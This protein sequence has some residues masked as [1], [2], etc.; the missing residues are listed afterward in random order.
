MKACHRPDEGAQPKPPLRLV[1][2]ENAADQRLDNFLFR[3]FARVP[4]SRIY[5]AIRT[6]EVRV[7]GKRVKPEYRI[8]AE[9]E[10]KMP[11]LTQPAVPATSARLSA[12]QRA[13]VRRA[14]L[15]ETREFIAFNKPAGWAVH[16]GSGIAFGFIEAARIA[17]PEGDALELAH[18][19]DRD[20]SGCLLIAKNRAGLKLLHAAFRNHQIRKEYLCVAAGHWPEKARRVELPLQRF[21]LANG[22]RRVKVA[23]TGKQ[24]VTRFE[25]LGQPTPGVSLLRAVPL[26]GR[27]HQIRVHAA[28]CGHALLGDDKYGD[29]NS[30]HLSAQLGCRMLALHASRLVFRL[31]DEQLDIRAEPPAAFSALVKGLKAGVCEPQAGVSTD[32]PK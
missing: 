12:P 17:L 7:N 23:T 21:V 9:D 30:R 1:V 4:K 25:R 29:S 18:R 31:L 15:C 6:G 13:A 27:T 20:T 28:A 2:S 19:L 11:A 14:M 32:T 8:E 16:G 22:E 5:R 26:T 3:R 24:A 10:L